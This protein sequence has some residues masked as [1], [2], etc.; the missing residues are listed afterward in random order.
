MR[1]LP[2]ELNELVSNLIYQI[3]LLIN[4]NKDKEKN[5]DLDI[6][7]EMTLAFAMKS[8]KTS[9]F[10]FRLKGIKD[11]NDIIEKIKDSKITL[12]KLTSLI[13]ENKILNEIFGTNYHSQLISRSNEIIKLLLQEN[14]LDENDMTLIW[15]CT[16][17][18]D[19]EAKLTILKLLSSIAE[20]LQEKH[21]EMLLNSVLSNVDK[22][23]SNEEIEFV[24]KLSTQNKDNETNMNHCCEYLC[25]CYLMSNPKSTD[26]EINKILEKIIL[27]TSQD[28]KYLKKVLNICENCLT[29]NDK[30]IPCFTIIEKI[31]VHYNIK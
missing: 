29:K 18:G 10:D 12:D 22:K 11:L 25:Q 24:F 1:K 21:I 23:I 27:V 4:K 8:L 9:I 19:L 28:D 30:T 16:K 5:D 31:L 26:V 14:A 6:Y 17:R 2:K 15:S 20:N 7:D 3:N 13:K